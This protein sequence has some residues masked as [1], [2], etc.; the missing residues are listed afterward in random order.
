[1]EEYLI[2]VNITFGGKQYFENELVK[3]DA[4]DPVVQKLAAN[5][6]IESTGTLVD[7]SEPVVTND[8]LDESREQEK[9][10]KPIKKGKNK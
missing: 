6:Y 9:E 7:K 4:A 5:E 1:M 10:T 2:K 8:V 3:F